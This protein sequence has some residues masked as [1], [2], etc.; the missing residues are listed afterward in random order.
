MSK[1]FTI[2]PALDKLLH[3]DEAMPVGLYHLHLL[4]AAQ[5]TRLQGYSMGSYKAIRQRLREL[6][7][8]GYVE[9]DA[10]PEKF[11]RGPNYYTLGTKGIQ[12]LAGLGVEVD[13]SLRASKETGKSYMHIKHLLELNDVF[14]AALRV[15]TLDPRLYVPDYHHERELKRTPYKTTVYGQSYGLVPD[16]YLE[17]H[18][19]REG[20]KDL[21]LPVYL[22]HD[23][24]W[25]REKQFK[26]KIAAYRAFLQ[27]KPRNVTVIV[28][29][30]TDLQRIA[31]L[32]TWTWDEVH[33]DQ[34]L[35]GRFRFGLLPQPPEPH[36][37]L[38]DKRWYTLVNDQPVSLLGD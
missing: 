14:I 1:Q 23:R 17:F 6:A 34:I 10:I 9:I 4:T 21:K 30:Y 3:G 27:D 24:G 20:E 28:T 22:E 33:S 12:Y 7:D 35:S 31:E 8:N 32:C 2:T 29:T 25:E 13:K 11:T 18:V 5:L 15:S 19:R 26:Q 37:V 36:H 16:G 38:L